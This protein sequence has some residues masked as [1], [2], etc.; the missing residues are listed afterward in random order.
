MHNFCVLRLALSD[1][2]SI[3]AS[4]LLQGFILSAVEM[5]LHSSLCTQGDQASHRALHSRD[6]SRNPPEICF[7]LP[8]P[9][10][11]TCDSSS[12]PLHYREH[13]MGSKHSSPSVW[14]AAGTTVNKSRHSLSGSMCCSCFGGGGEPRPTGSVMLLSNNLML[15]TE[16]F[17]PGIVRLRQGQM[18]PVLPLLFLVTKCK[19]WELS[20]FWGK[21]L[22]LSRLRLGTPATLCLLA[23]F[24]LPKSTWDTSHKPK[25]CF[26]SDFVAT[27]L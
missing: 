9:Q 22:V 5:K 20:A 25:S 6:L 26:L 16:V 23:F 21:G 3:N 10:A 7:P 12:Q 17:L 1:I 24:L 14:E 19:F 27:E 18:L 13:G 4:V 11:I 15:R 8:S 2:T